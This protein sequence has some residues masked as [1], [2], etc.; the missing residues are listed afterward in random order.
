MGSGRHTRTRLTVDVSPE[1]RRQIKV[2]A[3]ERDLSVND[4]VRALL[5]LALTVPHEGQPSTPR[6]AETEAWEDSGRLVTT[7]MVGR[8]KATR[9]AVMQGRRFQGDSAVLIEEARQQRS[10]DP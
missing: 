9:D 5:E 4:Y 3:A 8:L 1:L 10:V 7:E 6:P 2:H